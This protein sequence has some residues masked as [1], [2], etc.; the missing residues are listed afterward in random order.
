MD[1]NEDNLSPSVFLI[2]HLILPLSVF[3]VLI[4][5]KIICSSRL[6]NNKLKQSEVKPR[7]QLVK[8]G[9]TKAIIAQVWVD[10]CVFLNNEALDLSSQNLRCLLS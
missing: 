7:K 2:S 5:V 1:H 3:G 10:L 8:C 4:H 6:V 9:Q